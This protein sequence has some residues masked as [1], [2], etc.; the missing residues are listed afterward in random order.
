M[1]ILVHDGDDVAPLTSEMKATAP[2]DAACSFG[3]LCPAGLVLA[4]LDMA[5]ARCSA[6]LLLDGAAASW[7]D[8]DAGFHVTGVTPKKGGFSLI[9]L[10]GLST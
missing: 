8:S 10:C 7:T 6:W 2:S 5:P 9:L 1:H 3:E 4:A